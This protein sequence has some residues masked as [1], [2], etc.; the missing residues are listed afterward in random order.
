MKK[1]LDKVQISKQVYTDMKLS[2]FPAFKTSLNLHKC[3]V[4][5]G[6]CL[7]GWFVFIV[8]SAAQ[9][10][11]DQSLKD[12]RGRP[13]SHSREIETEKRL[14]LETKT[15]LLSLSKLKEMQE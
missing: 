15:D 12:T 8:S 9:S 13:Y 3:I 10:I 4:C 6:V 1:S 14:E 5:L 2:V 7:F 11:K